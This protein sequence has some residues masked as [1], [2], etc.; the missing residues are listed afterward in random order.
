MQRILKYA[1]KK[2]QLFLYRLRYQ[3]YIYK[4]KIRNINGI[5]IVGLFSSVIG[6]SAAARLVE[7]SLKKTGIPLNKINAT[8]DN[9]SGITNNGKEELINENKFKYNCILEMYNPDILIHVRKQLGSK[10]WKNKYKIAYWVWEL[11]EI[12]FWWRVTSMFYNEIWVPTEFVKNA[13]NLKNKK[14][15]VIPYAV[16]SYDNGQY[17]F[18]CYNIK[19]TDFKFLIIFDVLSFIE[20][21]NPYASIKSFIDSNYIDTEDVK[22]IIKL[23]NGHTKPLFVKELLEYTNKYQNI[24]IIDKVLETSEVHNLINSVDSLISLHRSE[25]FGLT[26]AEAMLNSKPV[27]ATGWSGNT[28]FMN[29]ENSCLVDY[30]LIPIEETIGPYIKNQR[31]AEPEIKQ[32]TNYINKLVSD[33]N[34]YDVIASKAKKS[35]LEDLCEININNKFKYN[36]YENKT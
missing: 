24:I 11:E 27:I 5:D 29:K 36:I 35:I 19:T 9:N 28:Q 7:S 22:L 18:S 34:F 16:S 6:L 3:N 30:K 33:K 12:P 17:D 20:R 31:W 2:I 10:N 1:P 14:I 25:G 21:K 32:S 26:L 8:F 4:N 23:N 15:E 13:L